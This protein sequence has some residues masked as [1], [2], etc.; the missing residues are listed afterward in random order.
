MNILGRAL[1]LVLALGWSG[2]GRADGLPS[3]QAAD[4]IQ[5][6]ARALIG[7]EYSVM[8]GEPITPGSDCINEGGG[9]IQL[10]NGEHGHWSE[11]IASCGGRVVLLLDKRVP[12][13]GPHVR[14]KIVD[15]LVL[16]PANLDVNPD[17]PNEARISGAGI[18]ELR[19]RT[20]TSFVT[21]VRWGK[22]ERIDWRTGVEKAWT[23]DIKRGRIVPLSTRHIV[24]YAY[25]P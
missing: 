20:D 9:F 17:E 4:E 18:C 24:C 3:S 10:A 1:M 15:A 6:V 5:Q 7:I 11:G 8:P 19:G 21:I 14:W 12:G 23:F 16:P 22:R 13:E 2:A 25:E